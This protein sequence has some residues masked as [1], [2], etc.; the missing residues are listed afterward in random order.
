MTRL[1]RAAPLL[2]ALLLLGLAAAFAL[3]AVDVRA[4]QARL[5]HDD[6]R[7]TAF[8]SVDGLWRSPAILMNAGDCSR[9][10]RAR[11]IAGTLTTRHG[12][13]SDR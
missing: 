4:W 3:L 5:R 8:R 2:A 13:G 12:P 11:R 1:R 9:S 7:F 6:V 10:S